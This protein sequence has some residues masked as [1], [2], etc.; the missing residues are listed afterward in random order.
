[1]KFFSVFFPILVLSNSHKTIARAIIDLLLFFFNL[2]CIGIRPVYES[3]MSIEEVSFKI[4]FIGV[5]FEAGNGT[6]EKI[7][8]G[9]GAEQN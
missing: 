7:W 3:K 8:S 1:M 4:N 9:L 6:R 2:N 5:I